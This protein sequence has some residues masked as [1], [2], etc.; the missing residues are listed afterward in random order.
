MNVIVTEFFAV[1]KQ[2]NM[3]V[4]KHQ[5]FGLKRAD[6]FWRRV[7]QY[8]AALCGRT[9]A[10]L[11]IDGLVI[12]EF[13][14]CLLTKQFHAQLFPQ[15]VFFGNFLGSC[16]WFSLHCWLETG[17]P[18]CTKFEE[19]RIGGWRGHLH[20]SCLPLNSK[21]NSKSNTKEKSFKLSEFL[22]IKWAWEISCDFHRTLN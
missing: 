19:I 13:L 5:C 18:E 14:A 7:H 12:Q 20:S 10:G 1:W 2:C 17:D 4:D 15:F 9:L 6:L 22:Q 16:G 8:E 11:G 3:W 21:S